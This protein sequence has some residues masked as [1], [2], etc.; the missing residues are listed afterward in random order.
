MRLGEEL[1]ASGAEVRMLATTRSPILEG[2]VIRHK[3]SFP[4]HFGIGVPMYLHNVPARPDA[5]VIIMTETGAERI[6]QTLR[7]HI[8]RGL[9]IDGSDT[10]TE[11]RET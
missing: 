10:I 7:S 9:I 3:L 1:E 6:C 5:D 2:A 11:F 8:G 4:D